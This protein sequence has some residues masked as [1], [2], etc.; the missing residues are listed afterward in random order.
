[1]LC[2]HIPSNNSC[3]S[4][5]HIVIIREGGGG[6][7]IKILLRLVTITTTFCADA[8]DNN[9]PDS[10]KSECGY[11]SGS[12]NRGPNRNRK[13]PIAGLEGLHIRGE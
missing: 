13:L 9:R 1:M 3:Y 6:I 4:T 2:E 12:W 11:K 5:H 10:G 7:S 8:D